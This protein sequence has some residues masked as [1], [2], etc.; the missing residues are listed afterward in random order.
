VPR[1]VR[2][3]PH[4]ILGLRRGIDIQVGEHH[5]GAF[6]MKSLSE[7][8]PETLCRPGDQNNFA[9][10]SIAV[11][12]VVHRILRAH[13]VSVQ[14]AATSDPSSDP[15]SDNLFRTALFTLATF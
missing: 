8:T 11:I 12:P 10:E 13:R 5:V 2:P 15:R 14:A 4:R 9:D 3:V 6:S 1:S 7:R